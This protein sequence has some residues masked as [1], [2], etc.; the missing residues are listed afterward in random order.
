MRTLRRKPI[1]IAALTALVSAPGGAAARMD[2][3][4][5]AGP[6][7]VTP[8]KHV[9]VIIGENRTFDN[10]YGTY[11]PRS[12][13]HV[14]NLLSKGIVRPDGSPG[15]NSARAR[16]FKL[17]TISPVSYFINTDTLIAPGKTAYAPLL[18]TPG[19]R[20]SVV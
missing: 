6:R 20:K 14:A 15:V 10:V 9:I 18:P 11:I 5:D 7:T 2:G 8:I 17:S 16:Q 19:D 1:A 12:G 4:R 3:D 13:Q